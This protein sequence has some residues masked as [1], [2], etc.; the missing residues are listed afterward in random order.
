[1]IVK[2]DP[3]TRDGAT[4]REASFFPLATVERRFKGDLLLS[5]IALVSS[6][7]VACSAPGCGGIGQSTAGLFCIA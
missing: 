6:P 3:N 5:S 2:Y 7:P 1:M 4:F